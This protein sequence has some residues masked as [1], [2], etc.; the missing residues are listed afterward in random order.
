MPESSS[1]LIS[2]IILVL[3]ISVLLT[4]KHKELD[5]TAFVL[6]VVLSLW[7]FYFDAVR[8]E[9]LTDTTRYSLWMIPLWIPLALTIL[10]DTVDNSSFLK[11][12]SLVIGAFT[13]VW[14]NTWLS[15]EKG[16]VYIGYIL[17]SRLETADILVFQ[18][19]CLVTALGL[20]FLKQGLPR[21]RLVI[22]GKLSLI[23]TVNLK[24]VVFL[25]AILLIL[26]NEAY[27]GAQFIKE[28][29][30]YK[31]HGIALM[32]DALDNFESEETLIFANN[33]IY[34]RV[35]ASDYLFQQGLLLSLPP[36]KEEFFE[37]LEIL[38]NNTL[39][40][41]STDEATTWFEYVNGFIKDYADVNII[42][43]EKPLKVPKTILTEPIVD[44]TFDDSNETTVMDCSNFK[45][46]GVNY[47]AK[48]VEG[49]YGKALQFNGEEYVSI[50]NNNHLA[51]QNEVTISFFADIEKDNDAMI[52]S[53]GY[54][55]DNGSL[56]I[57]IWK[58]RIYFGL[59][60]VAEISISAEP[61]LE[62]WH[63]FI[64]S[65][66]GEK[67][68]VFVD[69]SLVASRHASGLV[70]S[71]CFDLEIGRDSERGGL[72]FVGSIDELEISDRSLNITDLMRK[73]YEC[74][75]IRICRLLLPEG[76]ADLFVIVNDNINNSYKTVV[77]SSRINVSENR[78]L[79]ISVQIE[80]PRSKNITIII[81][82]DRFAKIYV[83]S[84]DSGQND[85]TFQFEYEAN[86]YYWL[87]L[88]QAR[89][90]VIDDGSIIYNNFVSTQNLRLMN[91][92]LLIVLLGILALYLVASH[93]AK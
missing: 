88:A 60:E 48:P 9:W 49:Y 80:S 47:G 68:D 43:P 82:T 53:K 87:Y 69:G 35:Y 59:G 86:G 63:H 64:F 81:A 5:R 10:R 8:H 14:I 62:A 4:H 32:S 70:R 22:G 30:L 66:D 67:M 34:T 89:I 44:M 17:P 37:L 65:Y 78:T 29:Q 73:S 2:A 21:V 38:P 33:Y 46:N 85:V 1:L 15:R 31:D 11:V 26:V 12:L 7:L 54:A 18:L 71:S 19:M 13:L 92:L 25:F 41:I 55:M 3:P 51:V 93:R 84:L 42:T 52:L 56:H 72:F 77:S 74:Y 20:L 27:F 57:F 50:L 90:L 61:Y 79:T 36:T 23:K 6:L 28:N 58:R 40:L 76:Q 16:G 91:G 45:N 24:D 39:L 75:A 83:T